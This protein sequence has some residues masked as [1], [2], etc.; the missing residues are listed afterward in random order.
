M[1]ELQHRW[2]VEQTLSNPMKKLVLMNLAFHAEGENFIS[3]PMEEICRETELD[4]NEVL[5]HLK[6][7]KVDGYIKDSEAVEG[8]MVFDRSGK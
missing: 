5:A 4:E 3:P 6:Q 1:N 7:L 8:A 2:I